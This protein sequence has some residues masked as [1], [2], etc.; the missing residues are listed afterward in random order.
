MDDDQ[1]KQIQQLNSKIEALEQRVDKLKMLLIRYVEM[2]G[3]LQYDI[4]DTN[5][6]YAQ[7]FVVLHKQMLDEEE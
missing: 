4:L 3:E 1:F 5:R 2:V 6:E 7:S